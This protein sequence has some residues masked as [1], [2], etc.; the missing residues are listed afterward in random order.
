M[1]ISRFGFEKPGIAPPWRLTLDRLIKQEY[2]DKKDT[3]SATEQ[4]EDLTPDEDRVVN[5]FLDIVRK[6]KNLKERVS[7]RQLPASGE[8]RIL[9]ILGITADQYREAFKQLDVYQKKVFKSIL[10]NK[11]KGKSFFKRLETKPQKKK[12]KGTF[13][14]YVD[15]IATKVEPLVQREIEK[16]KKIAKQENPKA[17]EEEIKDE[18]EEK[19]DVEQLAAE[20]IEDVVEE[21]PSIPDEVIEKIPKEEIVDIVQQEI[22]ALEL[23]TEETFGP[24]IS[25]YNPRDKEIAEVFRMIGPNLKNQQSIIRDIMEEIPDMNLEDSFE[26]QGFIQAD[27]LYFLDGLM[28][29]LGSLQKPIALGEAEYDEEDIKNSSIYKFIFNELNPKLLDVFD[30]EI[31]EIPFGAK[32]DSSLMSAYEAEDVEEKYVGRILAVHSVG[33]Q[34]GG[35]DMNAPK[36]IVGR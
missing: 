25:N 23:D 28:Q 26:L 11:A 20:V 4:G 15:M 18:V 6:M 36:V 33:L 13:D 12:E 9:K 30:F 29:I 27:L 34:R 35:K 10:K 1:A 32:F 17:D 22:D 21:N 3:E 16:T 31:T 19:I 7:P 24:D 14:E 8:N 2:S 5:T